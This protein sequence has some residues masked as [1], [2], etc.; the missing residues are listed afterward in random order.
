MI[1]VKKLDY[2][3]KGKNNSIASRKKIRRM[4]KHKNQICV[5]YVIKSLYIIVENG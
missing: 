4:K 5:Y 2:Q 1:I 3:N